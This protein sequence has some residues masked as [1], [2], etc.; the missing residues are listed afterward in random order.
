MKKKN[1]SISAPPAQVAGNPK[2]RV[3]KQI[4]SEKIKRMLDKKEK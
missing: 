4:S 1:V 3:V 2:K